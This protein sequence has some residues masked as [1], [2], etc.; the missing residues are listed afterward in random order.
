MDPS[1]IRLEN[2]VLIIPSDCEETF[3]WWAGGLKPHLTAELLGASK[4]VI[5]TYRDPHGS[6]EEVINMI[7][8]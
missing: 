3:R 7:L 5:E 2:E 8:K 4:E 6:K 1:D